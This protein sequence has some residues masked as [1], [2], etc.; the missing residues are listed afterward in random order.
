MSIWG[1]LHSLNKMVDLSD[2][3]TSLPNM[4]HALQTAEAL[5]ADDA[6][7]WMVLCGLLHDLGKVLYMKGC[8]S[9]GTDGTT[10][11]GVVGDTY[12]VEVDHSPALIFP[13]FNDTMEC[14]ECYGNVVVGQGVTKSCG[15]SKL[16]FTFGHDEYLW[17][18][19]RHNARRRGC[20]LRFTTHLPIDFMYV[21]RF[22]SFYAWHGG[23]FK[24][25]PENGGP[26]IEKEIDT[27]GSGYREYADFE[28][29][30]MLPS[31]KHFSSY[32]LYSKHDAPLSE[33]E[34]LKPYYDWLMRKYLGCSIDDP[35]EW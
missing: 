25:S 32:D 16:L 9:D 13:E 21:I 17:R 31:L 15:F 23:G 2:P 7:E 26:Q 20:N 22:H 12:P 34:K 1:A 11:W 27:T 8:A 18:V 6:P 30:V 28:D 5:R 29:V 10:Q 4:Q 35:L 14:T 24:R 19:L 3:D 33:P